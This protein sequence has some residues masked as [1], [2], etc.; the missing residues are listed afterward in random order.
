[1]VL[2]GEATQAE[3]DRAADNVEPVMYKKGQ[4]IVQA[5]Q[6]ITQQQYTMLQ[7]LGLLKE[8]KVNISIL[9]GIGMVVF[10]IELV[11][12]LYLMEFEKRVVE[13]PS[14]MLMI[15]LI[16]WVVLGLSLAT[17]QINQYLIPTALG[18]CS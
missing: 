12:I 8:E 11:V 9:L 2:D 1:M 7:K 4:Y 13:S 6:P 17:S 5:G 18:Q 3:K 14:H 10:L 16:V 15:S